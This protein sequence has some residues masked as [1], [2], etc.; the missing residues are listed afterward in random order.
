MLQGY[1]KHRAA[2]GILGK[3]ENKSSQLKEEIN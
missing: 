2:T 1:Y 3:K